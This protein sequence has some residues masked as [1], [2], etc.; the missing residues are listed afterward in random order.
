ML[1]GLLM[2]RNEIGSVVLFKFVVEVFVVR[3]VTV[4]ESYASHTF[5][6]NNTNTILCFTLLLKF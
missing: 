5:S 3:C 1:L 2:G 4:V 6:L